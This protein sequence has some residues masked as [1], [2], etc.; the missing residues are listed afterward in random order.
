LLAGNAGPAGEAS[1]DRIGARLM[2]AL[3][4]R[5]AEGARRLRFRGVGGA[6]MQQPLVAGERTPGLVSLFPMAELSVMG[7][8]ELLPRLPALYARLHQT[9]DDIVDSRP[10]CVVCVDSKGF[11]QR[12]MR[13]VRARLGPR[14]PPLVQYVAPSVWAYRD[15]ERGAR[16]FKG[17]A[18]H[19]LL[20][21]PFECAHWA[22]AGVAHT[23]VGHPAIEDNLELDTQATAPLL[24]ERQRA[25][26]A[27][28]GTVLGLMAGSRRAEVD[29]AMLILP[30]TLREL[31]A[32]ASCGAPIRPLFI[33]A[34]EVDAR[35]R[36]LVG[37]SGIDAD[38]VVNDSPAA[39]RAA[40]ASCDVVASVSGT[41]VL[42]LT[43]S[44][45][46]AVCFYRAPLVTEL[47]ARLLARVG[48]VS[49]PNLI[50]ELEPRFAAE[51]T[52]LP[53]VPE[54]LFSRCTPRGLADALGPLLVGERARA[55]RE[56]Q[57]EALAGV[58]D[59][60]TAPYAHRRPSELAAEAIWKLAP[61]LGDG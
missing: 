3:S 54:V 8:I 11:S 19:L 10:A 21:L 25:G 27:R 53:L 60:L 37:A 47:A 32:R 15:G 17:V 41:A 14:A 26:A 4:G 36:E 49:I 45:T 23:L 24:R 22:A 59:Y 38:L 57:L 61:A 2:R 1:G 12:V 35:V 28:L 34:P 31:Q 52:Q 20:L 6:Q 46:P 16:A 9:I 42:Q 13:G 7:L 50:V 48:H 5:A 33:N 55:A 56:A 30:D 18:D 58:C 29:A 51:R 44:R 40:L 39:L 43:L